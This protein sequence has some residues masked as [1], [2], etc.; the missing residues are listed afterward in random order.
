MA[1]EAGAFAVEDDGV[2]DGCVC[3]CF[4]DILMAGTAEVCWWCDD[5]VFIVGGVWIVTVEAAVTNGRVYAV[6]SEEF[7]FHIVMAGEAESAR[8]FAEEVAV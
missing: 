3:C 8:F 5:L 1:V 6:G 7:S 4:D 2:F